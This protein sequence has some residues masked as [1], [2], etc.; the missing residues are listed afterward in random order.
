[1]TE[2]VADEATHR[3]TD[4][5]AGRDGRPGDAF[6]F[7]RTLHSH[8]RFHDAAVAAWCILCNQRWTTGC[9]TRRNVGSLRPACREGRGKQSS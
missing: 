7:A 9:G 4:R 3:T 5:H 2:L 1:M 8:H 6:G